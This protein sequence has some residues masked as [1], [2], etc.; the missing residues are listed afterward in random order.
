MIARVGSCFWLSLG[1][2]VGL[3]LVL[4]KHATSATQSMISFAPFGFCLLVD[5]FS[6]AQSVGIATVLQVTSS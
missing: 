3:Q 4:I 5:P 1:R 6:I 2:Q